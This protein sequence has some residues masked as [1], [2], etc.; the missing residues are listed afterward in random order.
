MNSK[1]VAQQ[2]RI[3]DA[4]GKN[5]GVM[6]RDEALKLA[7]PEKGIDLIEIVPSAQPPVARLMSFDKY[8]YELEKQKKKERQARV[9]NEFKQIQVSARAQKNDLLVKSKQTDKFLSE[10]CQVEIQLRLRGREKYNKPWAME[11]LQQFLSMITVEYKQID[12][13]QFG[14]RGLGLHI[15]KKPESAS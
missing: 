10:N 11:R 3:I 5:L 8:R 2:L 15:I 12:T 6:S 9:K 14:G 1:I 7:Q 13:P 4:E